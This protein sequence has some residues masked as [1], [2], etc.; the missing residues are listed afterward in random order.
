MVPD[1]VKYSRIPHLYEVLDLLDN[2]VE[3]FEKIDGGNSQ[4]RKSEGRIFAGSRARFL[5]E[6]KDRAAW[7]PDFLNFVMK[8]LTFHNLP[9]NLIIFT[10]WLSPH[11]LD[12][13][14]QAQ[15]QAYLLDVYDTEEG[16]FLPYQKDLELLIQ[17]GIEGINFLVPFISNKKVSV[18]ELKEVLLE[19][20]SDYRSPGKKMEGVVV[21]DYSNQRFAKFW[22]R[23]AMKRVS[24][25][26]EDDLRRAIFGLF[27]EDKPIRYEKVS[28]KIQEN[29]Y[30]EQRGVDEEVI[31]TFLQRYFD[32]KRRLKRDSLR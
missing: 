8:N 29:L 23:S 22:R 26:D 7:F 12:Y 11:T 9:E 18:D 5:S 17:L 30:E 16:R 2:P 14:R 32:D 19:R 24:Y 10:E 21:K 31:E 4:I 27:D 13:T 20:D 1:F 25:I 28:V 15:D 6:R 3:V